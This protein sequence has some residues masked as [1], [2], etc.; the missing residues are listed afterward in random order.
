MSET[1]TEQTGKGL[2]H[3]REPFPPQQIGKLPKITCGAC[4]KSPAKVCQKHQSKSKCRECNNYIT[5]AHMHIDYVGHAELTQRLLEA[6]PWWNWEPMAFTAEGLPAFD[7]DGG[8][9]ILLTVCGLTRRGYGAAEGKKGPDATKEV[10]GDALRNAAMRFGA[11]L[12]LW[13]KSD[14]KVAQNEHPKSAEEDPA[15]DVQQAYE[16]LVSPWQ[17]AYDRLLKTAAGMG[18]DAPGLDEWCLNQCG[19][20]P[21]DG[22]AQDLAAAEKLLRESPPGPAPHSLS[23]A[24]GAADTM[25]VD[26]HSYEQDKTSEAQ[27]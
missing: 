6:D 19:G 10:I 3:L 4:S 2:G 21:R 17:L 1:T 23:D 14:L 26:P 22:N 8:L 24:Q 16:R 5:P 25:G 20:L 18:M 13:A 9:W 27:R 11:A 15:S 12:D 7:R